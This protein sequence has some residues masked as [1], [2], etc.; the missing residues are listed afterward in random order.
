MDSRTVTWIEK[1]FA[2]STSGFTYS[3][4]LLLPGLI[5]RTVKSFEIGRKSLL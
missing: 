3:K 2:Y 4:S 1:T 5:N